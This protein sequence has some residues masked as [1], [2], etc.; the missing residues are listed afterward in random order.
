MFG[1][2]KK[3][4]GFEWH[5]YVR[6]TIKLKRADRR[7]RIAEAQDAAAVGLKQ[8]GRHSIAAGQSLVALIWHWLVNGF[9]VVT[10]AIRAAALFLWDCLRA[11][12]RAVAAAGWRTARA[13]SE[14]LRKA[15]L[16]T[17]LVG[18]GIAMA[19]S[20]YIWKIYF[21]AS[22]STVVMEGMGL[23]VI[24]LGAL[25]ALWPR[26]GLNAPRWLTSPSWLH[27][28]TSQRRTALN[29][30][31]GAVSAAVLL[32]AGWW[33]FALPGNVSGP[34]FLAHLGS[35][36]IAG[37][38]TAIT[39]DTLRIGSRVVRLSGIEAPSIAQRCGLRAGQWP[40]GRSAREALARNLQRERVTCSIAGKDDQGRH[41]GTCSIG[42][43]DIARG[44]VASGSVF[45]GTGLFAAYAS[46]E[47][48]ARS[49]RRGIWRGPAQ[50]PSEYRSRRWEAARAE[51]PGGCPIKGVVKKGARTYL[52]PWQP[53]YDRSKVREAKGER[54]FCSEAEARAAGWRPIE[55][56]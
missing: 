35:T 47:H 17:C 12:G 9:F 19:G 28:S 55:S 37:R 39:G 30:A 11:A 56:S 18:L 46:E 43:R 41:L 40:C 2:R 32:L 22:N 38:A 53:E 33:V 1:W 21:G 36:T 5:K 20:A 45:G 48:E 44:L 34:P 7:R 15:G 42:S 52:T 51:A 23:L 27:F 25:A 26:I 8:A 29:L 6:T 31:G 50:R 14:L 54:W 13:A 3:D 16:V 24:T 49:K 10:S 4:E